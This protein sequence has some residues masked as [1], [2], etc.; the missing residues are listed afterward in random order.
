MIDQTRFR[1]KHERHVAGQGRRRHGGCVRIHGVGDD[2]REEL[3][4]RVEEV[5]QVG[6]DV[7]P[8]GQEGRK[9][10]EEVMKLNEV[11]GEGGRSSG[12]DEP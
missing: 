1:L 3:V 10:M 5:D 6:D 11:G 8:A 2:R 9:E 12:V 4:H 7:W